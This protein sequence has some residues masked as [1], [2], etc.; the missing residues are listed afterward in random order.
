MEELSLEVLFRR[1]Q[2]RFPDLSFIL[3][4]CSAGNTLSVSRRALHQ[5]SP[6]GLISRARIVITEDKKYDFQVLLRSKGSGYIDSVEKFIE[7]CS[8]IDPT[9]DY[10]FCP[11]IDTELYETRYR[12]VIRYDLKSVTKTSD[13]IAH[14][15]SAKCMF[16]HKLA[17]NSSLIERS[18][19]AV[20]CQACKRLRSDLE[21]RLKTSSKVTVQDKENRV[22]PSSHFPVKYLSPDSQKEKKRQTQ[23]ERKRDKKMLKKYECV[24]VSLNDEQHDDMCAIIDKISQSEFCL[25]DLFVEGDK[26]GV[27]QVGNGQEK[28]QRGIYEGSKEKQ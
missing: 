2:E 3:D 20:L 5:H 18:M 27:G 6:A 8:M 12:P 17:R 11:G 19:D 25:N 22:Q 23:L 14:I 21:Q 15:D 24:E 16:W 4:S 7:L 1:G 26:H 28:N 10:K 9:G 13:P